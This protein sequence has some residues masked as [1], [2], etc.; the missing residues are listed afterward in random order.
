M[1]TDYFFKVF[2]EEL[3]GQG[4]ARDQWI[5]FETTFIVAGSNVS[6]QDHD[7][8]SEQDGRNELVKIV[9]FKRF[10]AVVNDSVDIH[11]LHTLFLLEQK[12]VAVGTDIEFF[13]WDDKVK[14]DKQGNALLISLASVNTNSKITG[15]RVTRDEDSYW[16]NFET[17][18][19]VEYDE[20][21]DQKAK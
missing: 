21:P 7:V 9:A 18:S 5:S 16:F 3:D 11:M 6:V 8:A 4:R 13:K 20:L 12:K 2:L 1:A 14:R 10:A 17:V 15:H 19:P